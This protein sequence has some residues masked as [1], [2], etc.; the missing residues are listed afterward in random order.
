MRQPI[1][2]ISARFGPACNARRASRSAVVWA[3]S[4]QLLMFIVVGPRQVEANPAAALPRA[5][6]SATDV[7]SPVT[8][9]RFRAGLRALQDRR[10]GIA[11]SNFDDVAR[12]ARQ[13]ERR[14]AAVAMARYSRKLQ[15]LGLT[16]VTVA[17]PSAGRADFVV[18]TTVASI[19]AGAVV[20]DLMDAG[21]VRVGAGV[22]LTSTAL[23]VVGSLMGSEGMRITEATGEAYTSGVIWGAASGLLV[24]LTVDVDKSETANLITLSG[25]GLGGALGFSMADAFHPTRGQVGFMTTAGLMGITTALLGTM[26]ARPDNIESTTLT[27]LMLGGLQL[28][29]LGGVLVAPD[30]DWSVSRS[31]LVTLGA[32][33]GALTG[34]GV[35]T[36][37]VGAQGDTDRAIAT[38]LLAGLWAGFGVT[39]WLTESMT[40]DRTYK[41]PIAQ[42]VLLPTLIP[43]AAGE[44]TPG[45]AWVGQF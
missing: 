40:P 23:G 20:L 38:S 36:L 27:G 3:T 4:V 30:I 26:A 34:W 17:D 44:T 28:G 24:A 14:A 33:V 37:F 39:A 43:D 11:V 22:L 21:D 6:T 2:A 19:Y 18:T 5:A 15:A 42:S 25:V 41:S 12:Y 31:R 35:L 9:R 8:Q 16:N 7:D 13:A 1:G 32:G 10:L 45:L 29:V